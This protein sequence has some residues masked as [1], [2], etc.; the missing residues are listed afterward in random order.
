MK[1]S[2]KATLLSAFV[3]PGAGQLYLKRYR[4]GL[5]IIA[6]TLAGL[7][8]IIWQATVLALR[9]VDSIMGKMQGGNVNIHDLTA[10]VGANPACASLLDNVI[11]F[12]I[13]C[14][15]IVSVAD[16]FVSGRRK[17]GQGAGEAKSQGSTL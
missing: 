6:V 10:L 17:E 13:I 9:S 16:A 11:L 12:V 15:W 4:Q 5:I 7:G 1:I 14:C 3:F 8:Y 2:S